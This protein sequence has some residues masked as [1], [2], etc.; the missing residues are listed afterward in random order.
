VTANDRVGAIGLGYVGLPLA[1]R[2][3]EAGLPV[4]GFDI[5][6]DKELAVIFSKERLACT[7]L[8]I[9]CKIFVIRTSEL[10]A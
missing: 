8:T 4:L 3:A 7:S 2:F 1:L 6:P 9:L 5:D 10:A